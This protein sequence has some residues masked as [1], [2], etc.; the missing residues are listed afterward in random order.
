MSTRGIS[1]YSCVRLTT[2]LPFWATVTQSGN[3]NFLE[4]SGPLVPVMGL[5]FTL[6]TKTLDAREKTVSTYQSMRCH[7]LQ[8]NLNFHHHEYVKF[9]MFYSLWNRV[10]VVGTE[11]MRWLSRSGCRIATDARDLLFSKTSAPAVAPTQPH[12]QW[13]PGFLPRGKVAASSS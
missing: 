2:L 4:P 3:F 11:T 1:W 9:Y 10:S 13:A 6:K 7:N 8:E 12:I 5:I